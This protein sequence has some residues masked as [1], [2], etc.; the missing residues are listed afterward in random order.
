[1]K[2]CRYRTT[3]AS[4]A[5]AV[6]LALAAASGLQAQVSVK[7]KDISFI[8]GLKENQLYGYGLVVGLQGSGDTR[9]SPMTKSSLQNLSLIHISE[10]T[11]PY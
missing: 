11:R 7:L 9:R 6:I 5:I 3:M 1:M 10:P 8:D 2:G 4:A